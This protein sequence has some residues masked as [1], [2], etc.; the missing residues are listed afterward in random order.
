VDSAR[1]REIRESAAGCKFQ[2]VKG[3]V[4]VT[5][6]EVIEILDE[7]E[8]LRLDLATIKGAWGMATDMPSPLEYPLR[9]EPE[10][11]AEDETPA[12]V[13]ESG[14]VAPLCPCDC[15]VDYPKGWPCGDC[16]TNHSI[17]KLG[18]R[19]GSTTVFSV[20]RTPKYSAERGTFSVKAATCTY[21]D[22]DGFACLMPTVEGDRCEK[23]PKPG[24]GEEGVCPV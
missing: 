10:R 8:G 22:L 13:Q 21:T 15:H 3:G 5:P 4:S 18:W 6:A 24:D 7:M 1:L 9:A 19:D 11:Q 17:F 23:H 12:T 14:T 2:D 16:E 20:K